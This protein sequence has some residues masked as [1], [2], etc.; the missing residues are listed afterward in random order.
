MLLSTMLRGRSKS[1]K[2]TKMHYIN[3]DMLIRGVFY[4]K[5]AP[6][7]HSCLFSVAGE[8]EPLVQ[9]AAV[10]GRRHLFQLVGS[11]SMKR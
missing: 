9:V 3:I 5:A 2:S 11:L 6:P 8:S 10:T 4:V 1:L 7:P